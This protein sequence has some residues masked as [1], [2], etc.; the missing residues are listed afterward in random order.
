VV[1]WAPFFS[2]AE[3]ALL[4]TLQNLDSN[5]WKPYV[6]LGTDGE[7]ARQLRDSDV[8]CEVIPFGPRDLSHPIHLAWQTARILRAM[9]RLQPVIVHANEAPSFQAVGYQARLLRVPAST[10]IRFPDTAAGYQ[11]FL[12]AGFTRAIFVSRAA[13]LEAERDAPELF[14]GRSVSIYDPVRLPP[15]ISAS[16]WVE[17]RRSLGLATT[18]IAIGLVGQ[19]TEIKGTAELVE[20]AAIF[21]PRCPTARFVVIGEDLQGNGKVR[22]EMAQRV[23][24]LGLTSRFIFAGYRA[25]APTLAAALDIT[26]APSHVEPLGLSA[27]EAM[28]AGRPV[29]ASAV[30]GLTESVVDGETGLLV[31]PRDAP[32]LAA[33]LERLVDDPATRARF[34]AAGRERVR[35]DFSPERHAEQLQSLF[36]EVAG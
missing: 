10:H 25:D 35:T 28:A 4:Q 23:D 32:A 27:L 6:I 8:P 20:A 29:V 12:G 11:W 18:D 22:R 17:L 30:G 15:Q 5:R 26:A 14:D 34:G 33:A 16:D 13:R 31:P 2:G 36:D 9:R 7:L 19:V 24:A 1:A 21:A 3:R